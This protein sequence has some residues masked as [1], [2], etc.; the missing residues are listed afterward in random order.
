MTVRRNPQFQDKSHPYLLRAAFSSCPYLES[1]PRAPYRKRAGFATTGQRCVSPPHFVGASA[2]VW[3]SLV[4]QTVKK[5]VCSAG[6]SG[7]V[8]GSEDPLEEKMATCSSILAWR[9]PGTE[10]P[11][12]LQS[13]G[14][15]RVTTTEWLTRSLHFQQIFRTQILCLTS[16]SRALDSTPAAFSRD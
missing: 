15:Q 2:S 12:R 11:G 3:A 16:F 5:S 9:I 14:L 13:T 6:D 7:S 8:P 10:E 1:V 4:A